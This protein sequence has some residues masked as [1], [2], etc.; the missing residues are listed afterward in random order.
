MTAEQLEAI[1]G[2]AKKLGLRTLVHAHSAESMQRATR[3]GCTQIEHG[4]FAT[5]EVL[6]EM[7]RRGTYF[8][9]QCSLIFDNYLENRAKYEGIGNYNAEGFAA[10]QRAIP[11]AEA[12]IKRALKHSML[13]MVFGTDAV[14]GAHGRNAEDLICHVERGGQ[15]PMKAIVSAT[16]LGAEALGLGMV[17]GTILPGYEA[18]LIAV[19]GDPSR[20][21]TALRRVRFVMKGGKV[22]K[23]QPATGN[24]SRRPD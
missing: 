23:F 17:I 16:S 20:D 1:C 21:I 13:K 4:V 18:D 6:T 7:E 5:D 15:T 9:P 24:G 22:F 12:T 11:L 2:E 10:M 19:E 8:D 14:A 3:A